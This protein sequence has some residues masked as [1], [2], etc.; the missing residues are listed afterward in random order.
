MNHLSNMYKIEKVTTVDMLLMHQK[1]K[2]LGLGAFY[3][4]GKRYRET[5]NWYLNNKEWLANI[6]NGN[7]RNI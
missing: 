3:S 7:Y 4:M 6:L 1:L 2:R 5:V